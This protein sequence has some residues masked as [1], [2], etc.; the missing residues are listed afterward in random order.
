[1]MYGDLSIEQQYFHDEAW[2]EVRSAYQRITE[3]RR[4]R[5]QEHLREARYF[6]AKLPQE[7]TEPE[8][9]K[10]IEKISQVVSL[11]F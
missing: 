4:A 2:K 10:N 7:F 6:L 9:Y 5:A 8:L 11:G 1:M 3:G